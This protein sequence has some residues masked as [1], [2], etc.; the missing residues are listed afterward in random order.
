MDVTRNNRKILDNVSIRVHSL[1]PLRKLEIFLNSRQIS[2]ILTMPIWPV[3][4]KTILI[5]DDPL[6]PPSPK[7]DGV[8]MLYLIQTLFEKKFKLGWPIETPS[9]SR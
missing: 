6:P 1:F 9:P 2:K 7:L 5:W 4:F 3:I 8:F